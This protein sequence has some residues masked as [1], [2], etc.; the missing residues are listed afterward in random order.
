MTSSKSASFK[1]Y[2]VRV[3]FAVV[4]LFAYI[5]KKVNPQQCSKFAL[6]KNHFGHRLEGHII[7]TTTE[8]SLGTCMKKCFQL[9]HCLSINFDTVSKVCDLNDMAVDGMMPD[10]V[11]NATSVLSGIQAWPKVGIFL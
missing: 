9:T 1:H 6:N 5:F 10:V 8:D 2:S 4:I 11:Q 7:L 3:H